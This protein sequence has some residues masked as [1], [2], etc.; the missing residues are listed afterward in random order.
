MKDIRTGLGYDLHRLEAG[1]PFILGGIHIPA[2]F[3]PVGYSD[4]DALIHAI[5][6]A[7]I[8]ALSLGDIGQHFPD[9]DPEFKGINSM[10]LLEKTMNLVRKHGYSINNIDS[11]V[12]LES[13][14][15][16]PYMDPIKESLA[17]VLGIPADRISVKATTNE[18]VDATGEGRAIA[19]YT[20]ILLI[21]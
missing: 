4:G 3:G 6:D 19:V 13:P 7:M 8:G 15:I 16:S 9:T 2:D 10:I 14:R 12:I 1:R 21:K 20:S 11:T 17:G 18:R 5:C